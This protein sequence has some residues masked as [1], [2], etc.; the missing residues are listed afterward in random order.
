MMS[1]NEAMELVTV[2]K[3]ESNPEI[4]AQ[5]YARVATFDNEANDHPLVREV[6]N[7]GANYI[8]SAANTQDCEST[9]R[10]ISTSL[11]SAF[12]HGLAVGREME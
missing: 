10:A 11:Y 4:E 5:M 2:V 1:F 3:G 8:I 12:M 6:I 7:V 9:Q